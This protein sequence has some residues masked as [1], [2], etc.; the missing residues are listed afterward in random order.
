MN[1]I[2]FENHA[3]VVP[4][5]KLATGHFKYG[6]GVVRQDNNYYATVVGLFRDRGDYISV[7]SLKGKY[8]P[9]AGD[10]VIGLVIDV[11]LT[12]WIL[13]IG[14]PYVGVLTSMNAVTKRFDPIM[15]DARKIFDVGD[16][17]LAKI[18]AFDRT[19][20][21]NLSTKERGLGKLKGGRVIEIEAAHI[22]RV[23]GKKGSMINM[24]KRL[25]RCQ[26]ITG[27]NGRIWVQGKKIQDELRAIEAIKKIEREAHTQNLTNRINEFLNSKR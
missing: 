27:Q 21:P 12:N 11:G 5:D 6:S 17:V 10:L 9:R 1:E 18:I 7:K 8:L 4:G 19:K 23:I 3:I 13:D 26:I 15:A 14:S 25:T 20:D 22:P 16:I 2:F 24:I